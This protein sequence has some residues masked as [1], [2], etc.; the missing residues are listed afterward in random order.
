MK[1]VDVLSGKGLECLAVVSQISQ[2]EPIREPVHLHR[3]LSLSH[4]DPSIHSAWPALGVADLSSLLCRLCPVRLLYFT[5]LF[6]S[7][8][9]GGRQARN[10]DWLFRQS[11]KSL[12]DAGGARCCTKGEQRSSGNVD[13]P[14]PGAHRELALT[15]NLLHGMNLAFGRTLHFASVSFGF[16]KGLNVISA[17]LDAYV[18]SARREDWLLKMSC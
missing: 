12:R 8:S 14:S 5:L 17:C 4:G 6:G 15:L 1:P 11:R 10:S 3:S 18:A 16:P 7:W 13:R 2:G 9:K